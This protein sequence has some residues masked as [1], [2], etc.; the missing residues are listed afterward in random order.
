DFD[1]VAE[2]EAFVPLRQQREKSSDVVR[3]EALCGGELP[4]DR[5]QLVAQ[6]NQTLVEEPRHCLTTLT[7]D[8]AVGDEAGAFEGEDET[9]RRHVAPLAEAGGRLQAVEGGVDLDRADRAGGIFELPLL[10]QA[11]WVERAAAPRRIGPAAD[12]RAD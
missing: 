4:P 5:A 7:Q 11:L 9:L 1:R 10:R 2:G 12:A 3:I 6:F 8:F